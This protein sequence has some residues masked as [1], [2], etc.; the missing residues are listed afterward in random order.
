M[1]AASAMSAWAQRNPRR[2]GDEGASSAYKASARPGRP[3]SR[4]IEMIAWN[5]VRVRQFRELGD[6]GAA[7]SEFRP[8]K[9]GLPVVALEVERLAG[10][11]LMR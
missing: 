3:E 4:L 2:E 11:S 9:Q 8:A 10:L 1:R 5:L 7:C 6:E